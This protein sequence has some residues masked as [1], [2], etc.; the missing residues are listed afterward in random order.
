MDLENIKRVGVAA[1]LAGG[2][3]L[4]S[5][6]G[7]LS[8][9]EKKG[10]IDL[11]TEADIGS[12][13]TIIQTIRQHFPDHAILAEE[14]G[15]D[16]GMPEYRW[17]IDP[18]DGTT[19]F[20]HQ[21]PIFAVSIAFSYRDEI[22]VGIV[23]NPISG[24]L[25]TAVRGQG[26]LLN[27]RPIHVSD[28]LSVSESL[29]VTGFPYNFGDI[30]ESVVERFRS[31]LTASRGVRRLG[32]AALDLCFVACGRFDGFWEENL[33]PWDT[34]AGMLIVTEAGGRVTDFKGGKYGVGDREI[35]ATNGCIHRELMSLLE[36]KEKL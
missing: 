9:I 24:E 26:A 17:I 30:L 16:P 27:G 25:F 12:E 20:A 36:L 1:A 14:S 7:N 10:A 28:S 22:S 31:C 2:A 19:N 3:V 13:K 35:L 5:Y 33:K 32:A 11:V 4:R 8:A 34:A 6:L 21:L 15:T 29:L 18:L 23:V